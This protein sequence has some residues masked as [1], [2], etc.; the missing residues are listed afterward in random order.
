[1]DVPRRFVTRRAAHLFQVMTDG[2]RPSRAGNDGYPGILPRREIREH[3]K[4]L[5]PHGTV[6]GVEL[7]RPVQ[8]NL[9][10]S[11]GDGVFN[12]RHCDSFQ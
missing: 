10:D 12:K 3:G 11:I 9:C 7:V 5:F 6:D 2:E 8:R 1:M 4:E